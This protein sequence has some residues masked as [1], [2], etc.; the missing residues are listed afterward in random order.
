MVSGRGL[1]RTTRLCRSQ[2]TGTAETHCKLAAEANA[3]F[4]WH[5]TALN[6]TC[7]AFGIVSV[8]I[9]AIHRVYS[10]VATTSA[11]AVWK[12]VEV[13]GGKSIRQVAL[14]YLAARGAKKVEFPSVPNA[15]ARWV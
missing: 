2:K 14:T 15:R 11:G 7:S 9:V 8:C 13:P 10:A 12:T 1:D 6:I 5:A 4:G 3:S